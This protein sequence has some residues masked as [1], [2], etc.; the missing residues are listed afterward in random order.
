MGTTIF[1]G[2][3]ALVLGLCCGLTWHYRAKAERSTRVLSDVVKQAHDEC[4][5]L[6][7]EISQRDLEITNVRAEYPQIMRETLT[8]AL[9]HAKATAEELA[10][11]AK[12]T[13]VIFPPYM[14]P[15]EG[16]TSEAS[17]GVPL[18]QVL[19]VDPLTGEPLETQP[20]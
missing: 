16:E 1:V 4:D 3:T 15:T 6:R 5:R 14:T 13:N 18:E 20:F 7:L 8:A 11:K 12:K 2:V 9:E 17:W 19:S 10:P